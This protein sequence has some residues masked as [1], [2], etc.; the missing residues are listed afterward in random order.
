MRIFFLFGQGSRFTGPNSHKYCIVIVYNVVSIYNA[1]FDTFQI[2]HWQLAWIKFAR[3]SGQSDERFFKER[4]KSILSLYLCRLISMLAMNVFY[5]LTIMP[6]TAVA[7]STEAACFKFE[8]N[9]AYTMTKSK[10]N[11]LTTGDEQ[12]CFHMRHCKG[13]CC[14]DDIVSTIKYLKTVTI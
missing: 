13:F 4:A 1:K 14:T 12:I 8:L 3:E 6:F 10:S 5:V 11:A 7:S 2:R 9:I